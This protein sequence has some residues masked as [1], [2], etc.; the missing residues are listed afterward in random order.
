MRACEKTDVGVKAMEELVEG[1]EESLQLADK[2]EIT[3]RELGEMVLQRLQ[4]LSE[5]AYVRF[6]SVYRQ[7]RGVRDFMDELGTLV[8]NKEAI[9]NAHL[10]D[11][12]N[13]FSESD[14]ASVTV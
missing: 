4:K 7:F 10:V 11:T 1:L 8:D 14:K 12:D 13:T 9:A 3:T 2:Q 6:A 5:V